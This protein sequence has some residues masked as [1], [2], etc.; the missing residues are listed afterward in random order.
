MKKITV[1][2]PC[3]NE[4]KNIKP[5]Y[6]AL[7][8]ILE[9][10]TGKY[11]YEIIFRDNDSQDNSAEI[12]REISCDKHVKV[13][14]NARN[15]GIGGYKDTVANRVSGDV[16]IDIPCDFQEPP[17]LIPQFIDC[18]ELGYE[19]VC[20]CKISSKEPKVKYWL[21]Q[22]FYKIISSFSDIPQYK[23][24]SGITLRSRRLYDLALECP[25]MSFRFFIADL[26]I[27]VKLIEYEQQ[28]RREG[29]SKFNI[30]RYLSFAIDSMISTSTFPLRMA[31]L[32]GF[33]TS[34]LSFFVGL[35]YLV[36]KLIFWDRF[37]AGIAPLLIGIF[38]LG[39]IQLFF[40]GVVGEYVGNI[41]RKV[42]N[43]N[44]PIV[45]ELINFEEKE[46]DPFYFKSNRI[47]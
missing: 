19:A 37:Y 14:I 18:W 38:F 16:I 32:L 4:E 11:D 26:G 43:H 25:D 6:N 10:Y 24:I 1:V 13:I 30:W 29:K 34:V 3:Y 17:E 44:P 27:D 42:S 8:S 33:I 35:V 39:S 40:I 21:R 9:K 31:S 28:Q 47:G 45:K 41:L 22:L 7:T 36:L 15:Y 20:G 23:N 12:Y 5:M 46:N 2:V